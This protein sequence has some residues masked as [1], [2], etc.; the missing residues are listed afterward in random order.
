MMVGENV[1]PPLFLTGRVVMTTGISALVE[2]G[3]G[4]AQSVA[5]SLVKHSEGDWGV[6]SSNWSENATAMMEGG[7]LHSAWSYKDE[8]FWIITEADRS[9]TTVLLPHEY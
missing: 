7:S 4:W 2:E 1:Q 8:T 6:A 5:E 3:Q 9:A